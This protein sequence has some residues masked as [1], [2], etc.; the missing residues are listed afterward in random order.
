MKLKRGMGGSRNGRGRSERTETYK[1]VSKKRRR[2]EA[3]RECNQRNSKGTQ[4]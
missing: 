1:R 4:D 2:R 3:R